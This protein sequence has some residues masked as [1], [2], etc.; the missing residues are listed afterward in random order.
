MKQSSP[1]VTNEVFRLG[2][3]GK[4]CIVSLR[5]TVAATPRSL[6]YRILN[7]SLS[8]AD[9]INER[10]SSYMRIFCKT[11]MKYQGF[12]L[13]EGGERKDRRKYQMK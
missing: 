11:G 8:D 7:L 1:I 3:F 4:Y 6:N 9:L 13:R 5:K 12:R 10:T 2:A